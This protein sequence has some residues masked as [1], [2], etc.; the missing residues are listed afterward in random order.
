[1]RSPIAAPRA[2]LAMPLCSRTTV[3]GAA[4]P[5]ND[6]EIVSFRPTSVAVAEPFPVTLGRSWAVFGTHPSRAEYVSFWA[7]EA[8]GKAMLTKAIAT[9]RKL[10]V[11]VYLG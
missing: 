3:A 5:S 1:M 11:I 7:D 9:I 6:P 2:P 10:R 4:N 8:V